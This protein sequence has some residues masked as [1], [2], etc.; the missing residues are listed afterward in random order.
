MLYG[1]Y[2]QIQNTG[3]NRILWCT[4]YHAHDVHVT[5]AFITRISFFHIVT[6]SAHMILQVHCWKLLVYMSQIYE[7]A[8]RPWHHGHTLDVTDIPSTSR[9]HPGHHIHTLD[10]TDT[11][12]TRAETFPK[13]WI[14]IRDMSCSD[15]RT[16]TRNA[17]TQKL[18]QI[19]VRFWA[20]FS[21]IFDIIKSSSVFI[22]NLLLNMAK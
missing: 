3:M 11:P 12:R 20:K 4:D 16:Y 22:Q 8:H 6:F 17:D 7:L 14:R 5:W 1:T 21:C 9:R 13:N 19:Y 2:G 10:V 15:T 18:L